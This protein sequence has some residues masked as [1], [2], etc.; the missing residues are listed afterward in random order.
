MEQVE[1][2]I[3]SRLPLINLSKYITIMEGIGESIDPHKAV[4]TLRYPRLHLLKNRL[5]ALNC[6][7]KASKQGDQS[8]YIDILRDDRNTTFL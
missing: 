2:E 1:V 4:E 7:S 6:R 8:N 5:F 3:I